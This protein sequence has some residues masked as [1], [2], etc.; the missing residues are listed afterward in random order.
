MLR[1]VFCAQI[2][3]AHATRV[4]AKNGIFST[5][6]DLM[7]G[8]RCRTPADTESAFDHLRNGQKSN[9]NK[10]NGN[11]TSIGLLINP[12]AKK[13][14]EKKYHFRAPVFSLGFRTLN[15]SA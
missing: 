4:S 14:M 10:I 8:A 12:R 11:V 2:V 9:N 7:P 3:I 5:N 15:C 6:K 1:P 13:R